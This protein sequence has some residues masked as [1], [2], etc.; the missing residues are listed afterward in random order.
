MRTHLTYAA[1]LLFCLMF[2]LTFT[3]PLLCQGSTKNPS[4]TLVLKQVEIRVTLLDAVEASFSGM[5]GPS[6]KDLIELY[7]DTLAAQTGVDRDK[8]ATKR[9]F[10]KA[11]I[12]THEPQE[13]CD[14][15]EVGFEYLIV[16]FVDWNQK[17][18]VQP[19]SKWYLLSPMNPRGDTEFAKN[20]TSG[21][22]IFGSRKIGILLLQR[23]LAEPGEADARYTLTLQHKASVQVTDLTSLLSI[24]TGAI[25]A[26]AAKT[27]ILKDKVLAIA[28]IAG[29]LPRLPDDLI[30]AGQTYLSS[31]AAMG[32]GKP[33]ATFSQ[34]Y[35][36]EGYARWDIS[37]AVPVTGIKDVQYTQM[38][39]AI[40]AKTITRANAYGL[41]HW[42]PYPVD[43]KGDY[44]WYPSVVAGLP[45]SGQPLDKPFAGLAIGTRKPFPFQVNVFAGAVFN[46]VFTPAST[47]DA[48]LLNSHRVT[49]LL[50]G[51]DLPIG[52]LVAA[53]KGK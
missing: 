23:G 25:V 33:D 29:T 3:L 20:A 30:L 36:D 41:A 44:P 21:T 2:G 18:T 38:G 9:F 1:R 47:T 43:L 51:I 16:N 11:G 48:T 8:K 45:L 26:P 19:V 14:F 6:C 52:K 42:Y 35:D 4:A 39:S 24:V 46:K 13:S 53:I 34:T 32:G 50:Y 37:A 22:R 31:A 12:A 15:T 7:K 27:K 5:G 10:S 49:K 28:T 40:G 17:S